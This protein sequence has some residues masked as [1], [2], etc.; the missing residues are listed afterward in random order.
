MIVHIWF[1]R[2]IGIAVLTVALLFGIRQLSLNRLKAEGEWSH[3]LGQRKRDHWDLPEVI[4]R[5]T[6]G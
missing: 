2:S 6:L 4:S 1:L 3:T 5:T